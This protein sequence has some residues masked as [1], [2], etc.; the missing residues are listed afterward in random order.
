MARRHAV[1]VGAL[2]VV[3]R[4]LIDRLTSDPEWEVVGLSRRV[5][6][7]ESPARFISVDLQDREAARATLA[8][9]DRT[10]HVFYSA[11]Q[12][13]PDRRQ[14]L[15]ANLA[16]LANSID[17][18]AAAAPHLEH[19]SLMEGSKW[20]GFHLGPARTPAVEDDPR[21]MPP[22]FY[23]AQHDWLA[24][25]AP[26][27]GFTWSALRPQVVCGFAVGNPMNLSM[28]IAVY[29]AICAELDVPFS[30]PGRPGAWT[31]LCEVTDVQILAQAAEWAATTPACAGEAF[32]ITNGDVFRWSHL[33][34]KLA[35]M[36]GVSYGEPR[37]LPLTE[38]MADKGPVWDRI[39]AKHGLQ[40]YPYDKIVS[41]QFADA[42]FSIDWDVLCST[43][44]ARRYGFNACI[45]TDRMFAKFYAELGRRRIIPATVVGAPATGEPLA[46]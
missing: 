28:A 39:V 7:F 29:A 24:R 17:A 1:V 19:V 45:E 37:H 31:S 14:E 30:F 4:A 2:G 3:G 21:H 32:N 41:W 43:L 36:L 22:N 6:D 35:E 13:L 25:T 16:L 26:D 5:P 8:E 27:Y 11:Y 42:T 38:F 15:D 12:S 23:Y 46:A 9:L 40:P 10:T 18:L 44:K 34:P 33:W 20:Y